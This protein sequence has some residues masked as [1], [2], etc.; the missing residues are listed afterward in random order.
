MDWFTRMFRRASS[1]G[2]TIAQKFYGVVPWLVRWRQAI[3][4]ADISVVCDTGRV[5]MPTKV[6]VRRGV[7]LWFYAR[8]SIWPVEAASSTTPNMWTHFYWQMFWVRL[9]GHASD[10]SAMLV[11]LH[12]KKRRLSHTRFSWVDRASIIVPNG[13]RVFARNGFGARPLFNLPS[14]RISAWSWD[15]PGVGSR[16]GGIPKYDP[17]EIHLLRTGRLCWMLVRCRAHIYRIAPIGQTDIV[18]STPMLAKVR[19]NTTGPP[20]TNLG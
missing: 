3:C 17:T 4:I 19:P 1:N 12:A 10:R 20:P 11:T 15:S 7:V 13:L 14:H 2:P 16:M 8:N 18:Q 6:V 9:I 5:G